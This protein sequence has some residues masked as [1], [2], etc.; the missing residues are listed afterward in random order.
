MKTWGLMMFFLLLIS[1]A[2]KPNYS[3]VPQIS[4]KSFD[5]LTKDSA[6]LTI[7]FSDGDGDLGGGN[8]QG[9][10]FFTYYFWDKDSS[11][12]DLYKDTTFLQD[13]IDARTFPSPS[14]AYKNKPISGEIAVIL[15]DF[16]PNYTIKKL[17]MSVYIKD[18]ADN[19]S[20]VIQT[21]DV[22]AP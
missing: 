4:F 16:R 18:N 11:K 14:D 20:N 19:K 5:I 7:N 17:K 8:G 13:T 10:I 6:I 2:K 21:P 9:N 15:T 3:K 1:C 12:Y 22:Y